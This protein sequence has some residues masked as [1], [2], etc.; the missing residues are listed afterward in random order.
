MHKLTKAVDKCPDY[1]LN[2]ADT[3]GTGG[4]VCFTEDG[5]F[6]ISGV[7]FVHKNI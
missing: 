4:T 7:L 1:G 2:I 5:N 6:H 3:V